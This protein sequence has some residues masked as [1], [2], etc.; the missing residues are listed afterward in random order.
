MLSVLSDPATIGFGV[1]VC[2]TLLLSLAAKDRDDA[3]FV[4]LMLFVAWALYKPLIVLFGWERS[5]VLY[6]LTDCIQ[7]L[8]VMDNWLGHRARWKLGIVAALVAKLVAHTVFR[9][10]GAHGLLPYAMFLNAAFAC[11]LACAMWPGGE[12]V[13]GWIGHH[14]LGHRP[15]RRFPLSAASSQ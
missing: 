14:L 13:G 12:R 11:E 10:T 3:T 6:P 8:V 7:V 2:A 1:A 4:S 9:V 15:R 5:A